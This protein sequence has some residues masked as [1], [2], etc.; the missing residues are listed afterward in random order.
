[1]SLPAWLD[2]LYDGAQ[3]RAIDAWAIERQG[4][5]SLELM[6][7]AG[8]GLAALAG[9]LAPSGRIV[10]VA[11]KGNNGGDGF[12]AARLLRAQGREVDVLAAGDLTELTG[13]AAVNLER[14]G[15]GAPE[16]LA[17]GIAAD[18]VLVI[19]AVLGTG[20]SGAPRGDALAAIETIRS[21]GAPVL[22]V[23][24]PSGVDAS[25]GEIAGAAV[26]AIATASFHAAKLGLWIEPGRSA[27]GRVRVIDIGMPAGAPVEASGGLIADR[28]LDEIPRRGDRLDEVL[29]R[30]RARRRGLGGADRC[31]VPGGARRRARGRRLR[32]GLR[33]RVAG[34]DLPVTPARA[35]DDLTRRRG[36]RPCAGRRRGPGGGRR[37]AAAARSCSVPGSAE[38]TTAFAFA[39]EALAAVELPVVLDAD[40][41][42][43][44][45]GSPEAL[46]GRRVVADTA[47]GRAR[48]SARRAT[49]ARSPP[50]GSR[51][52]ARP[53][54]APVP[55]SC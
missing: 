42:N 37:R 24:V 30:A 38:A 35:D 39:R 50:R 34:G 8:E 25:S 14:L 2:P 51:A 47:R 1:M 53:P 43:A 11:G 17:H 28:V 26:L 6:E 21:S 23:D 18:A 33:A 48:A 5:P 54:S 31:S 10:V 27:A 52:R 46:R 45:A 7:R 15:A 49:R 22:A 55:W 20:S 9:E 3:M 13:D 40:G 16:P 29:E 32:H 44:F 12:V 41:L 4:V 19:D 36:R